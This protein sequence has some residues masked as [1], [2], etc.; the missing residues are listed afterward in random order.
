[1]SLLDLTAKMC[2]LL[3]LC[4][5][6]R[7]DDIA[8]IDTRRSCV[9]HGLLNLHIVIPKERRR[10]YPIEK[11]V[12]ISPHTDISICPAATYIAYR[13]RRLDYPVVVFRKKSMVSYQP[14]VRWAHKPY[15]VLSAERI[16]KIIA[17]LTNLMDLPEDT[18]PLKVRAL[19]ATL[20]A[21]A[22]ISM[23]DIK[24]QGNWS[25]TAIVDQFYRLNRST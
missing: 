1:M 14:L 13:T 3:G 7:P 12:S 19:G 15:N 20:A 10:G 22:N 24:V 2:W 11:V 5:F 6:L 21:L 4:G 16:G 9:V 18:P 23:D 25:S 8:G 17:S